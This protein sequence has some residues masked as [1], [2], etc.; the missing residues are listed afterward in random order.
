MMT[1]RPYQAEAVDAI[2]HEWDEDRKRTL[3]VLPTGCHAI[4]QKLLMADGTAMAVEDI[5]VEYEGQVINVTITAGVMEKD[6]SMALN[7]WIVAA[8]EKLYVGKQNGKN[9]V[10]A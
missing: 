3:L 5:H 1:L 9:T 6:K 10:I 2:L 4:G 7:K 8:D